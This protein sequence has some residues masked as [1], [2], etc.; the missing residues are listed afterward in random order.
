MFFD[1]MLRHQHLQL[2]FSFM[3]CRIKATW[4]PQ[5][6]AKITK[7]QQWFRMDYNSFD[8]MPSKETKHERF[9]R[10]RPKSLAFFNLFSAHKAL[11]ST[12]R[13][14]YLGRHIASEG[15]DQDHFTIMMESEK[16]KNKKN[17][18]LGGIRT[19]NFRISRLKK[20]LLK[21]PNLSWLTLFTIAIKWKSTAHGGIRTNGFKI[22]KLKLNTKSQI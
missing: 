21:Y 12:A 19:H 22:S 20:L 14:P 16:R 2:M 11:D 10:L 4:K 13:F 9:N 8:P 3:K 1:E 6:L 18:T 5:I 15:L 7:W 17:F